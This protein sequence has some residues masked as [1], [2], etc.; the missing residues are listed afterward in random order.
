M[1][2]VSYPAGGTSDGD[3]PAACGMSSTSGLP[4]VV[5][6]AGSPP[7]RQRRLLAAQLAVAGGD[8]ENEDRLGT[9]ALS[10]AD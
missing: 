8:V 10:S 6:R 3:R 7:R 4:A 2:S 9:R 1:G 5:S